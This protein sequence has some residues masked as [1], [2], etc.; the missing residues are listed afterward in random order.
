MIGDSICI[1][2]GTQQ[3]KPIIIL[4]AR[5]YHE[6]I[7]CTIIDYSQYPP[8][9][10]KECEYKRNAS[11][12]WLFHVFGTR[13]LQLISSFLLCFLREHL[14]LPDHSTLASSSVPVGL[15]CPSWLRSRLRYVLEWLLRYEQEPPLA[16]FDWRKFSRRLLGSALIERGW[17]IDMALDVSPGGKTASSRICGS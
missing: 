4:R 3:Q 8:K 7:F 16:L 15:F 12:V 11:G 1:V 10:A 5:Y 2:N 9:D 13:R 14:R 6:D 17:S